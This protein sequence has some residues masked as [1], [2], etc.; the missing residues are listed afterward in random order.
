MGFGTLRVEYAHNS[1]TSRSIIMN[2]DETS[3]GDGTPMQHAFSLFQ[4][5]VEA[6][7]SISDDI[8]AAVAE[9]LRSA[10]PEKYQALRAA[11]LKRSSPI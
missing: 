4:A 10:N 8:K 11:L 3:L 5:R 6:D 7:P 2:Q 9:D 1:T